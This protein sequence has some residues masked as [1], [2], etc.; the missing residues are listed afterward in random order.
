MST[1]RTSVG[2]LEA[3][4][5]EESPGS[6]VACKWSVEAK[7]ANLTICSRDCVYLRVQDH[8]GQ[9]ITNKASWPPGVQKIV[10]VFEQLLGDLGPGDRF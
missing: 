6:G 9:V 3:T 4:F 5:Y 1:S 10:T 2:T 7:Y 8:W